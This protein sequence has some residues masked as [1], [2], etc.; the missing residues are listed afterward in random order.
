MGN[1][2]GKGL[3]L[4]H[5]SLDISWNRISI[6]YKY[7]YILND[8]STK[9]IFRNFTDI[10]MCTTI[11]TVLVQ[12][13]IAN[14]PDFNYRGYQLVIAISIVT[15][16]FLFQTKEMPGFHENWNFKCVSFY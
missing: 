14:S 12:L 9:V 16:A 8:I 15:Y 13:I 1:Y 3:Y 4:F 5:K 11:E 2:D 7:Q 6:S 10:F